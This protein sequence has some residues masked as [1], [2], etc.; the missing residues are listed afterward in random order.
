MSDQSLENTNVYNEVE[1]MIK[2]GELVNAQR[3]LD[4]IPIE[5]NFMKWTHL[6]LEV[7]LK[8]NS[9]A[10]AEK[11]LNLYIES[12]GQNDFALKKQCHLYWIAGNKEKLALSYETLVQSNPQLKTMLFWRDRLAESQGN[13]PLAIKTLQ[14]SLG[15]GLVDNATYSMNRLKAHYQNLKHAKDF[16]RCYRHAQK[17]LP[18]FT[19]PFSRLGFLL[20]ETQTPEKSLTI[21][22]PLFERFPD[23]KELFFGICTCLRSSDSQKL[24]A[25]VKTNIDSLNELDKVRL[26]SYPVVSS[27]IDK[28]V[29]DPL[30]SKLSDGE[31]IRA[32]FINLE[33]SRIEEAK[34]LLT[35]WSPEKR[36]QTA[37]M[38]L[39]L[40]DDVPD[41]SRL[42]RPIL[43][44]YESNKE[45]VISEAKGDVQGTVLVFGGLED[46]LML[47]LS[48]MDRY[49]AA[50][51]LSAV[52]LKD[53][54]RSMYVNGISELGTSFEATL[55]ALRSLLK[56]LKTK[57][58]FTLGTSVGGFAS[59]LYGLNLKAEVS[60]SFSGPSFILH[61]QETRAKAFRKRLSS[62]FES[63]QDFDIRS[64]FAKHQD[65][66]MATHIYYG[67]ANAEDTFQA[68]LIEN[69]PNVYLNAMRGFEHHASIYPLIADHKLLST[70]KE[71]FKLDNVAT[72]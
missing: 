38:M 16:L 10:E 11:V 66:K 32:I 71:H 25:F 40:L 56:T 7:L 21:L 65:A 60:I 34:L 42:L 35:S 48:L 57:R 59:M 5:E 22:E 69:Y 20:L 30:R 68:S 47:P 52:Y 17:Y 58:L 62:T 64:A 67:D 27:L 70:L 15:K 63:E 49:F 1:S 33:H 3:L 36:P 44:T 23:N 8:Q 61:P 14:F 29:S 24:Y 55:Q 2:R 4:D 46:Q 45:I 50:L 13:Y 72:V 54:Q 41:E 26:A 31:L 6:R 28:N 43:S 51:N 9:F 37:T 18:S 39:Q 19:P 12:H 53:F